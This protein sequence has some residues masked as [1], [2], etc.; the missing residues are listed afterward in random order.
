MKR[1]NRRDGL[2]VVVCFTI[3]MHGGGD[4]TRAQGTAVPSPWA[5]RDIGSPAIAGASS[6]D[7]ASGT[8]SIAAAGRDI[9]NAADQF[10][11]VYQRLT[12]D[13][14]VSVKVVSLAGAT[15]RA[16]AGVMI[17]E[18]L[19]PGSAH[20]FAGLSR[21]KGYLFQRRPT[22]GAA[23]VQSTAVAGATPGWVR[24]KRTGDL[25]TG[26]R[27]LDGTTWTAIGSDSFPMAD[28]VYVGI[29]VT[30]RKVSAA[31]TAS[32]TNLIIEQAQ[33]ANQP[34]TATLSAPVTGTT[35][36][37]PATIAVTA[38]ASDG[39]GTVARVDFYNGT[40]LLASDT[41]A[42]YAMTWSNVAAGTYALRAIAYDDVGA[43]ATSATATITVA[44]AA[45]PTG[46]VFQASTDHAIVTSY[47]LKIFAN[48][49]D[50][51]TATPVAS[52][53]LGKPTPADSGDITVNRATLF[54]GL[55]PGIYVLTVSSIGSGGSSRSE[56][57]TFTR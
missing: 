3:V 49:A 51:D 35:Y 47:L 31:T 26:Y 33:P 18:D 36:M 14:D 56:P 38:S 12:G 16:K 22:A 53:D 45:L 41:T 29:A 48:G 4:R 28:T 24:L 2:M 6:F 32:L 27:S 37:A 19:T 15:P 23:S 20:A 8:F 46:V 54:S 55:A 25:I 13:M 1:R 57:L 5:S 42:P 11:Y 43:S 10:H 9:W 7:Q 30:S 40:T 44:A 17:R 52:S 50:P 34:P 21:D 39:D